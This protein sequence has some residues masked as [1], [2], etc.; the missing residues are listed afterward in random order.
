LQ[1]QREAV[2]LLER[3]KKQEKDKLAA[4]LSAAQPA[5]PITTVSA[6]PRHT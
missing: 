3:E 6:S 5:D 2:V 1:R 4:D